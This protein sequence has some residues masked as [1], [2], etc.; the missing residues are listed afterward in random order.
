MARSSLS[1]CVPSGRNSGNITDDMNSTVI[2]G[3]PRQNSIN[4]TDTDFTIG[5]V[6]RRPSARRM[7]SGKDAAMPTEARTRVRVSPPQRLVSTYSSP[8]IPPEK[9]KNTMIG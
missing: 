3:T 2:N 6:E 1:K 7:P 9:R 4:T 8:N 5:M